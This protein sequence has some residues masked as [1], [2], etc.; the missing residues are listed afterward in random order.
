MVAVSGTSILA[1]FVIL[2]T[3]VVLIFNTVYV[4]GVRFQLKQPGAN[5]NLS[6]TG[7]NIIF[8]TDIILTILLFI[9]LIA[10]IWIIFT[11]KE[12]RQVVTQ[13]ITGTQANLG[14][15]PIPSRIS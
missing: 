13:V 3:I 11:T 9:A 15:I 2:I 10:V 5:V 6:S 14:G 8:W 7:A 4:N 1:I 12:Q